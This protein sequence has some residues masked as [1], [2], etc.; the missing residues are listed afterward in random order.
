MP[1]PRVFSAAVGN[2]GPY[3]GHMGV[4]NDGMF[5]IHL[6]SLHLFMVHQC[7]YWCNEAQEKLLYDCATCAN[8]TDLLNSSNVDE[9]NAK[10][11]HDL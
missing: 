4:R 6:H 3:L 10:I 8:C 11:T 2:F 9:D 1:R 7:K 5:K